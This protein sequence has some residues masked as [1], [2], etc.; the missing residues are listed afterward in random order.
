MLQ[1]E[2]D[3]LAKSL[4]YISEHQAKR[5][6]NI[7]L[8]KLQQNTRAGIVEIW[9]LEPGRNVDVL[10]SYSRLV[11]RG[12]PEPQLVALSPDAKGLLVWAL[13]HRKP[14][15]LNEIDENATSGRNLL[16]DEDIG[17]RYFY[18]FNRTR[19]IAAYP[20]EYRN[21]VH[22]V[23]TVEMTDDN[24]SRLEREHIRFLEQL[25]EPTAI[26]MWKANIF[27]ENQ[28]QAD[29]AIEYLRDTADEKVT[30]RL[31]SHR[32]GFIA[33]AFKPEFV[34]ISDMIEN[35]F[36]AAR[37]QATT[38]R[39]RHETY[40]VE[41]MLEQINV[42]HFCVVDITSLNQN[43]LIETGIIIGMNKPMV[44]LQDRNDQTAVPFD[45]AGHQVFRYARRGEDI[46]IFD[47]RGA[48][49]PVE[50]FVVQYIETLTKNNEDFRRARPWYGV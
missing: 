7:V 11:D 2:Y 24:N 43:V 46:D 29:L 15:W 16:T 22:G 18:M 35:A 20:I 3:R 34:K 6:L 14:L 49:M 47:A 31:A 1:D 8:S 41:E 17:G 19:A 12:I 13:E 4:G 48:G 10:R 9:L 25:V 23:L 45:I 32:T 28:K 27:E 44:I 40:V 33:A 26:L 21:Q 38:Y 36:R 37:V 50:Y 39:P 42:A 5:I 30:R